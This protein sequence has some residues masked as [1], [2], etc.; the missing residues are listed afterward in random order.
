MQSSARYSS[1]LLR[2]LA[3]WTLA[4]CFSNGTALAQPLTQ[5]SDDDMIWLGNSEVKV[6]LKKSSGGAI[7]WI[8][9]ASSQKN[10][11]NAYDRGRLI[12]QSWYGNKDDSLWNNKPWSWNPVQGGDW[13][14][15]SAKILEERHDQTSSFTRTRP[16]HCYWSRP[17]FSSTKRS[18]RD[19]P[20]PV[21]I[22]WSPGC[23]A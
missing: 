19:L 14:G 8:S 4:V 11:I 23:S 16:V 21:A 9:S 12:Q 22:T 5:P 1:I 15:R 17:N 10:L 2:E 20:S 18:N 6:G 3:I 13:R 7:A